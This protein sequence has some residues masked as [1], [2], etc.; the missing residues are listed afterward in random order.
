ML[1]TSNAQNIL[2][3]CEHDSFQQVTKVMHRV[4][5]LLRN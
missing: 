1:K 4:P 2:V 3:F 5:Y